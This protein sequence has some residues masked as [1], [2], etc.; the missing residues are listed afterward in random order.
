MTHGEGQKVNVRELV[1]AQDV[2]CPYIV[3][4]GDGDITGPELMVRVDAGTGESL[5]S[6]IRGDGM[7]ITGLGQDPYESVLGD[8]ACRPS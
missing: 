2:I 5:E 4:I 1:G 8:R 6:L 3:G 7:G